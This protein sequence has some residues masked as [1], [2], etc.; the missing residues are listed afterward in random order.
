VGPDSVALESN[1]QQPVAFLSS[2]QIPQIL[3]IEVSKCSEWR[4]LKEEFVLIDTAKLKKGFRRNVQTLKRTHMCTLT[5][6]GA[7]AHAVQWHLVLPKGIPGR[8]CC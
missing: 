1:P 3:P 5:Y 2:V 7:H 6:G 4:F 8:A